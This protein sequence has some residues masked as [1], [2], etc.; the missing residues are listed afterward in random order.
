MNHFTLSDVWRERNPLSPGYSWSSNISNIRCRLDF[1]LISRNLL[2]NVTDC[3]FQPPILSDH[4]LIVLS[5]TSTFEP[6]GRGYWKFNNSL[7]YDEDYIR[8]IENVITSFSSDPAYED[9]DF[10]LNWE[11]LKFHI[12]RNTIKYSK[13]K[14][15]NLQVFERNLIAKIATLESDLL[16]DPNVIEGL[17]SARNDLHMLYRHK[18]QGIMIRSKARWT[19]EGE[20]NSKYFLSL[21]KRNKLNNAIFKLSIDNGPFVSTLPVYILNLNLHVNRGPIRFLGIN[22]THCGNDLY[23]LNYLQKLSRLKRILHLWSTR[24]LSPIGKNVIVKSFAL[25]QLV[26][27]FQVLPDPPESFIN[28]VQSCIFNF[29]WSGNPDKVRRKTMYNEFHQG[30]LKVTHI[31]SF[32]HAL[33]V[34]WVKRYFNNNAGL[35]KLFFDYYLS[36]FGKTFLFECNFRQIDIIDVSNIFIRQICNAW[37]KLQFSNPAETYGDQ[38]LWNNN[39]I[40]IDGCITYDK[41]LHMA[42]VIYV[43]DLFKDNNVNLSFVELCNNYGIKNYPFTRYYGLL[44]A[45]PREWKLKVFA[46]GPNLPNDNSR[47]H[48]INS[49]LAYNRFIDKIVLP[50]RSIEKWSASFNFNWEDWQ[51]I[52]CIPKS[53]LSETKLIYFQF[54]F[55]HRILALNKLLYR[56]NKIDNPSCTFCKG[57]DETIDH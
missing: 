3:Y 56:M 11:K 4:S 40:K 48:N 21:E 55:L 53:T 23:R 38:V 8:L 35:W 17:N 26:F 24:D 2:I 7:L 9:N 29:I 33:K 15:H 47:L 10:S 37:G 18:L 36:P 45:I 5:L 31:R 39:F 49:R 30:G 20:Q 42:G 6:R 32:I 1:F 22:F 57:D 34:T 16:K 25:S 46:E 27:L 43:R 51:S 44:S 14:A 41:K 50:P 13:Q 19:E 54:K 52:F 12:R 28:E